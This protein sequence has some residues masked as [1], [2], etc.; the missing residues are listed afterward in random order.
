VGAEQ[1]FLDGNERVTNSNAGRIS[2][3]LLNGAEAL[4]PGDSTDMEPGPH[5]STL[6]HAAD[7]PQL[8][9]SVV[10]RPVPPGWSTVIDR[11]DSLLQRQQTGLA[12]A[13]RCRSSLALLLRV[14]GYMVKC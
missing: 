12:E 1:H 11:R 13:A 3:I 5:A 9:G 7:Q 2:V 6:G 4:V 8:A 14:K 10:L